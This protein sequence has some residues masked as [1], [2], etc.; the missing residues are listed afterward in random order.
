MGRPTF[1]Q[2]AGALAVVGLA[3]LSYLGGAAVMHFDLPSS[4][5]LG[6]AFAG[7]AARIEDRGWLT[8]KDPATVALTVVTVD[9]PDK[10]FDG[11]TLTSTATSPWI[12][13]KSPLPPSMVIRPRSP[14]SGSL[15][16]CR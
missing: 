6:K 2:A 3:A 7:A 1:G 13:A 10:T 11:F 14:W 5:F 16:K 12:P 4:D 9:D 8:T 15:R